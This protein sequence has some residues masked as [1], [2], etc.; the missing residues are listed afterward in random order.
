MACCIIAAFLVAQ[1]MAILRRWGVFWGLLPVPADEVPDTVYTRLAGWLRRPNVRAAVAGAL[2]IELIGAGSWAYL[3]HG[4]HISQFAD[5]QW[6]RL[7]GEDV[8]Y[9][10]VCNRGGPSSIRLVLNDTGRD[11]QLIRH[12]G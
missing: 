8:V 10:R 2:V 4:E 12:P 5:V 11:G 7:R 6:S 9:A 1:C 3:E